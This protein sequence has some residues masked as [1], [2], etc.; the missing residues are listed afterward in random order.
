MVVRLA[1]AV[2]AVVMV[3][4]TGHAGSLGPPDKVEALRG[5]PS[6]NYAFVVRFAEGVASSPER[7]GLAA[8]GAAVRRLDLINGVAVKMPVARA[9]EL[10]EEPDIRQVWYLHPDLADLYVNTIAA[11]DYNVRT[12]PLPSIAN[13]SIGPMPRFWE[14]TPHEDAP[15]HA[16]TRAAAE[17]GLIPVIAVGNSGRP[18]GSFDGWINP[19]TYPEWVIGVGAYDAARGVVADF[20]SRGDPARPDTWPDV[21]ADG[22]DVIGPFPTN[23]TKSKERRERDESNARFREQV[24][25]EKWDLYTLESGTS[26]ATA[27]T[28]RAA[29]QI[30]HFL[31]EMISRTDQPASGKPIFSLTATP[32]RVG[33]YHRSKQRLTGTATVLADGSVVYEYALDVPWKMVK[34][35]LID[36]A[37]PLPDA[38]PHVAGAGLVDPGYI[39]E[40]FGQFG[41]VDIEIAPSKVIGR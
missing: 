23:L 34:Q 40:Q 10:A 2:L 35:L 26:Q 20:S 11:L 39:R 12:L 22:V 6:Q 32:D 3:A 18:D 4:R 25:R 21:V 27:I 5:Q 36:A 1:L 38:G 30:L 7:L 14:E 19:W 31:K 9:F 29:A 16:A 41:V 37:L 24:P 15:V 13:L 17:A 33:G 8:G 28:S